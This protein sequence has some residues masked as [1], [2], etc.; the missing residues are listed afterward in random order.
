MTGLLPLLTLAVLSGAAAST[1]ASTPASDPATGPA[2]AEMEAS[3]DEP[4]LINAW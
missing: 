2:T 4:I 3:P 1:H